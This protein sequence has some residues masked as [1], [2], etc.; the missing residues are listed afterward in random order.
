MN[1]YIRDSGAPGYCSVV[2]HIRQLQVR[3]KDQ[4]PIRKL[5]ALADYEG[6]TRV[7]AIGD[8]LSNIL[9]RPSHDVLMKCLMG[10]NSDYTHKQHTLSEIKLKDNEEPVSVDL[11]AATDRIPALITKTIIGEYFADQQYAESWYNLMVSFQF[12][13]SVNRKREIKRISYSTGQPMGLY[14][15]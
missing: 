13:H 7:I 15:S 6:K 1:A 12:R 11:T 4:G 10:I 5:T 9:L 14:S 8:L 2:K 3:D